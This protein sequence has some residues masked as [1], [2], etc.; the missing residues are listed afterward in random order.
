MASYRTSTLEM[1]KSSGYTR[2]LTDKRI[3]DLKTRYQL[4]KKRSRNGF[5]STHT[6]ERLL[7]ITNWSEDTEVRDIYQFFYDIRE[8]A[9]AAIDDFRLLSDVLTEK[10]F[11]Q[12]LGQKIVDRNN[13]ERYPISILFDVLIPKTAH[14]KEGKIVTE[15]L[16]EQEWRKEVLEEITKKSLMWYINSGLIQTDSHIRLLADAIDIIGVMSSGKKPW[17]HASDDRL[18]SPMR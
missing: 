16:Q 6:R 7:H 11:Q 13:I 17:L 5:L 15:I 18:Q 10:E 4:H 9:K 12:L 2:D 3:K 8:H 1:T 14:L